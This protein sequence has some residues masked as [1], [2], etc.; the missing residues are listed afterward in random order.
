MFLTDADIRELTGYQHHAH[1]RRWLAAR[2]WVFEVSATGRPIVARSYAES[3][4]GGAGPATAKA[5]TPNLAAIR[6][7]A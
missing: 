4:L 7:A 6:K 5:W 3:R 1:Q 2:G